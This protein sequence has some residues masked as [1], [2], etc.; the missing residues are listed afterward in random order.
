LGDGAVEGDQ[1]AFDAC[2]L[3]G[4]GIGGGSIEARRLAAEGF[5]QDVEAAAQNWQVSGVG[6]SPESFR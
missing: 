5:A 3:E 1:I 4:K 2:R 6:S